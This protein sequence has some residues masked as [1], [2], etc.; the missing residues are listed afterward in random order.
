M[1]ISASRRTDVPAFY[2]EWFIRRVRTGYC[3][4]PNPVNPRQVARISLLPE[5]VDAIVFW[6][7][8]P[9]PLLSR[10]S[11][12]D[13]LGLRYYFQFTLCGYG[14]P[15]EGK[16]PPAANGIAAFKRLSSR[17][18][19]ER[20]IWR[21]DPLVFSEATT[22]DFHLK[23]FEFLSS[24]LNGFTRRCVVSIWDHY[25]KLASRL[26]ALSAQGVHLRQ[27]CQ[28]ELKRLVPRLV[29]LCAA[30]AMEIVSCAEEV[31][32]ERYGVKRGKCVDDELIQRV[33]GVEVC[34]KKD[35]A[36]RPACGCVESRDVGMYNTC[37]FGCSYCYAN[38]SF[39]TAA[40]NRRKHDPDSAS[41]IPPET[42]DKNR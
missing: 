11:E 35:G 3:E 7:R 24:A 17:V 36:Q 27:P 22:V 28:T 21:Y 32:L 8:S 34:H 9:I 31:D 39:S 6:T 19:P 42:S 16:N 15:I 37:L 5:E 26:E 25:R 13:A 23:N 40:T 2:A 1:I 29:E 14:S 38:T 20:V 33:F 4:V 30:N 12:L 41:L 18:G 10:L